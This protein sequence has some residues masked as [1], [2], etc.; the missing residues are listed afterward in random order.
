[1][2]G[3]VSP[4]A[5]SPRQLLITSWE[6][7]RASALDDAESRCN[8]VVEGEARVRPGAL[9]Q[10][11]SAAL[12]VTMR[13]AP[14]A[15]GARL[16]G[17]ST[18]DF[19]RLPRYLAVVVDGGV[20]RTRDEFT[21]WPEV[22]EQ[23][24]DRLADRCA[25]AVRGIPAGSVVSTRELLTALGADRAYARALPRWLVA[26]RR[27]GAPVHRVLRGGISGLPEPPPTWA[28]DAMTLL[29]DEGAISTEYR[30]GESIWF[31]N[32]SER[33]AIRRRISA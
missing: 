1:M 25:W 32:T 31:R 17:A 10:V 33:A 13:C 22:F 27:T 2:D 11:G 6:S 5:G 30:L 3:D 24:P 8:V 16:A 20:M 18:G 12:R 14:C 9:L 4:G 28:P 7:L 19:D 26:A 29:A 21:V 23:P 15:R